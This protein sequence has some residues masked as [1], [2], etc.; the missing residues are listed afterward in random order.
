VPGYDNL[1]LSHADRRRVAADGDRKKVFLSSA[2]VK[3][4]FLFDGFVAGVWKIEKTKKAATLIV[5]PFASL[6][7]QDRD[8]LT[9]EGGRLLSFATDG[10]AELDVR[11]ENAG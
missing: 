7:R 6:S 10:Q 5:E 2:R 3:A 9:E 11:F 4:T 1:V 8:A